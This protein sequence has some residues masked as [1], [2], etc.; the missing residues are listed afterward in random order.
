MLKKGLTRLMTSLRCLNQHLNKMEVK[1]EDKKIEDRLD[2][3]KESL[4][5]HEMKLQ[6]AANIVEQEKQQLIAKQGAIA[7]LQD[8]LKVGTTPI[9]VESKEEAK[10]K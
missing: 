1:M 9:E 4:V 2:E 5:N 10:N 8:L 6:S 3:L 7:V